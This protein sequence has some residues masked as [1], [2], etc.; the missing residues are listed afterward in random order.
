MTKQVKEILSWYPDLSA[1]QKNNLLKLINF[2]RIGGSG[3]LVIL[4]VD[5]GF[6]HG[7][8][9]SFSSNPAG[10]NPIYHAELAIKSGCNAYAAPLGALETAADIIE[11]NELPI[12]LKVNNHDLM[13]PDSK[14]YFPAQTSW[15]EDAVR[16]KAV[17]VGITIYPGSAHAKEMY[18][19]L[20]NLVADA[21]KAGLIVVVWT[22]P[23][24]SGLPSEEAETAV[25]VV[26]YAVHVACQM[27]AHIV[28]CKTTKKLIGIESNVKRNIYN[29]LPIESLSQRTKLVLQAAFGGRRIVICSGGDTKSTED[30]LAEVRE[31]K[32]GGAFGS[33][34]GRNSF[35]RPEKEAIDLLHKIQDIYVS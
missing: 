5:Q 6:E 31:L 33:I 25:D 32:K 15:V 1:K 29:G 14:D 3:K 28:K 16:L 13:M 4:P 11:K 20:K 21:R 26:S 23:R 27:G 8:A 17:A 35:Q 18:E 19:Q 24:G 10:Y 34:V 12:I 7:P 2:G 30:I 22:Y 9:R